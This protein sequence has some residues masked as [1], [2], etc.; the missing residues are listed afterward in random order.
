MTKETS[1]SCSSL[2]KEWSRGRGQ[3]RTWLVA[4]LKAVAKSAQLLAGAGSAHLESP[5]AQEEELPRVVPNVARGSCWEGVWDK[6]HSASKMVRSQ[7]QKQAEEPRKMVEEE[8]RTLASH[9]KAK[10]ALRVEREASKS[11]CCMRTTAR[12]PAGTKNLLIWNKQCLKQG[13]KVGMREHSDG[14]QTLRAWGQG[15]RTGPHAG[16]N[17]GPRSPGSVKSV[18]CAPKTSFSCAPQNDLG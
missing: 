8:V 15:Q 18:S 4:L 14:Y 6:S 13:Q 17:E 16:K 2:W 12:A 5:A 9:K 11:Q 3:W 1:W 7:R 10:E